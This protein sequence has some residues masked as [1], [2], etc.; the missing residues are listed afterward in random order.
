MR[1]SN[2]FLLFQVLCISQ[3]I[4]PLLAQ[5]PATEPSRKLANVESAIERSVLNREVA[6][7]VSLVISD[8]K[9]VHRSAQG[10]ADVNA[11]APMKEDAIFW[12]ASM[13]KP[14]TG[15]CV[16]MLVDEGKVALTDPI[17]K[18]LPEMAQ[19]KDDRG[20]TAQVTVQQLMNHT[21]GMRELN[22]PYSS[23]NLAEACKLYA[24][25][26]IQFPPGS[27]WQYSQTSINTA[28]RIV[29]V[30]SGLSF[31]AFVQERLAK[32]LGMKDTGFY[33][34]PEQATR[35]AKSYQC[36]EAGE[37]KEAK[38]FLLN[39]KKPTD[40]DRFP[41]ANGGLFSTAD[42]YGRFCLM[43]LNDGEIDGKRILTAQSVKTLRTPS[44]GSLQ[45]GFTDGNAWGVG[46]CIVQSPQGVTEKLS[47]GSYGHG[48]AYGTQ[49]WI[50][51][52]K[53]RAYVLMVQR[54]NFPNA[55]N[56]TIRRAFQAAASDALDTK[57]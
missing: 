17:Q 56:S 39:G 32:P 43:L 42:D 37:M 10:L 26:G 15:A 57:Q 23:T 44:T 55:D 47:P 41:A 38:I 50:D 52:V 11:Q 2:P 9:V 7:A 22:E 33:L 16:M 20:N 28:A 12:I 6:G 14:V 18:F 4:T 27:K 21:S 40:R 1:Q 48:G 45:V 46:A 8:G 3:L 54:S 49:A 36:S 35:L 31:D 30:V 13:S 29:E 34:T 25:T 5:Q 24:Q 19:L 51:P 53:K